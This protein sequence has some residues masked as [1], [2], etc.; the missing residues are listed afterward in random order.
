LFYFF[1]LGCNQLTVQTQKTEKTEIAYSTVSVNLF[2][3][4]L[5]NIDGKCVLFYKNE[6]TNSA[7]IENNIP[8][9]IDAP[10]EFIRMPGTTKTLSYEYGKKKKLH[11][12]MVT[13]GTPDPNSVNADK[14]Q[15]QGCGTSLQRI[16]ISDDEIKTGRKSENVG[17]YCPSGG[18]DEV[19]F[20]T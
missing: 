5:K 19:F 1:F 10:C 18:I 9:G 13:G 6:R 16:I 4:T 7:Q 15:P 3:L 2:S 17:T 8:V 20:A 11:V 14:L 12:V